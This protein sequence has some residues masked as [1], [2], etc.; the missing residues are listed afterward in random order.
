[1]AGPRKPVPTVVVT[2]TAGLGYA[3]PLFSQLLRLFCFSWVT[4][5]KIAL[6]ILSYIYTGENT[7][8]LY[9]ITHLLG[10]S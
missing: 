3:V 4:A 5:D 1:M 7:E 8:M 10:K 6:F 2:V 9:W